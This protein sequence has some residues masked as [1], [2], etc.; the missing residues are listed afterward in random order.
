VASSGGQISSEK[1]PD[2]SARIA[3]CEH[4]RRQITHNNAAGANDSVVADAHA[5]ADH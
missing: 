4:I 1:L 5:G 3:D 2:H